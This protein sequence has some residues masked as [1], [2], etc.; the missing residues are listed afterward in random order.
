MDHFSGLNKN[1][2]RRLICL[3]AH[4]LT[5]GTIW[6]GL[7]SVA[8]LQVVC[9]WGWDLRFQKTHAISSISFSALW[10][11]QDVNSQLLPQSHACL[12]LYSPPER[13]WTLTFGN[14][15]PQIKL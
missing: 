12:L 2:P 10:L 1:S 15:K 8:L 14:W 5:S 13:S 11:S 9:P 7:G 6:K 4:F 3:T